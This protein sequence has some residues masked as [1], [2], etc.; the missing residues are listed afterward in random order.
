MNEKA[1]DTDCILQRRKNCR[2]CGSVKL[3]NV[4]TLTPTPPAN[5]FVPTDMLDKPQTTYPLELFLCSDCGHLQLLDV[6]DPRE[7]FEHYVYVSGTSPSFVAHFEDYA[8]DAIQRFGL[9]PGDLV[10][11]IGS[12]DG[13][14]LQFFKDA[15]MR[16]L[17]IDPAQEVAEDARQRGIDTLTG[18]FDAECA[19]KILEREGPAALITA[20][21]VFA[22]V[23][24]LQGIVTGIRNLLA[25]NGRFVF[26]VSYLKDV[27]NKGLFDTIYHEHLDYHCAGP[28]VSFFE[29]N[30]M[31]LVDTQHI[32]THGG[33]LRGYAALA[34]N[35]PQ[36][37]PSVEEMVELE[38]QAGL[39]KPETFRTFASHID[40]SRIELSALLKGLKA[41]GKSIAAYG[42][43]AKATTLM[44]HFG[45]DT[46]IIEYIVDDSPLK[47]GLYTPGL[48]VPVTGTDVLYE[49]KPD[50]VVILAWNFADAIISKHEH[51]GGRFIIPLPNLVIR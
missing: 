13:T 2:L 27:F 31:A 12:N 48:H 29:R 10:V 41:A 21:N 39:F 3:E 42:A 22:H 32:E 34:D 8:Q 24:D 33:S 16:V 36:I 5:A 46:E 26:E 45:L 38:R 15:G 9:S 44:Y 7:L 30:N 25:P 35:S 40:R 18:F 28:L 6:L 14:L 51:Y 1:V 11:D 4:L 17:G 49:R 47:Q 50:Y 37:A 20:N 23:D 19:Q 43:P